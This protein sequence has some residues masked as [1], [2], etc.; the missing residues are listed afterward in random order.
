M[1][2]WLGKIGKKADHPMYNAEEAQRL[3]GDLPPDPAGALAEIANWLESVTATEGYAPADRLGVIKLLD[4]TGQARE[5]K[6]L[7]DF[8]RNTRLSDHERVKL[9]QAL[10]DFWG[11]LSSAYRVCLKEIPEGTG[12]DS[13]PHSE[14]TLLVV[15]A[16]R[17]LA[18]EAKILHLR[19][20]PVSQ[21]VWTALAEL[22]AL[23]EK[24]HLA[25]HAVKPYDKELPTQAR[26][27][28]LRE[29][30]LDAAVPESQSPLELEL[31]ARIVARL[32]SGF[33]LHAQPDAECH[34][35]FDLARPARPAHH[36]PGVPASATMRYFGAGQARAAIQDIIDRHTADPEEQ[37]QRFGD[38]YSV[39][40]KLVILK[41][42][43]LYWGEKPPQRRTQR[44]KIGARIHVAH[45]FSAASQLVTRIEFSGMAE[46]TTNM[47]MKMKEQTGLT[48]EEHKASTPI[49]EWTERDASA[50]GLGV[51]IPRQDE[52]WARIGALCA[53]QP[54]GLK[55][56]WVGVIRRLYRD[57][58]NRAHAGIEVFGK[59]PLSVYLR[60]IGEDAQR[61]DNWASSSGSFEFTYLNALLLGESTTDSRTDMLIARDTFTPGLQ[62]EAMIGE[63]TPHVK[64]EELL[65][66]GE[67]YDRVRV[68]WL[69]PAR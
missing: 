9:W 44:V 45:G 32:A 20:M 40:D 6:I 4:E 37:E 5:H 16:L 26:Q 38:D 47:S 22:Y 19:Y 53:F 50:W 51:D 13:G 39:Q 49:V 29:L 23:S 21:P 58:Q 28:F 18:N 69:K 2:D 66:R 12:Q 54:A 64:L 60:G 46:V 67:D 57:E 3:L 48:L 36:K 41:R 35:G 8:L 17:A 10:L 11:H 30:M 15:R 62:Y 52:S 55:A 25:V 43:L 1:L 31:T 27:E 42:L 61:A 56:W 68:S 14:R 7:A 65:E 34:F 24:G 33:A 63:A 59:K